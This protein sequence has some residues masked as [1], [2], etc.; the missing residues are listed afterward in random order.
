MCDGREI[1]CLSNVT[2]KA[3]KNRIIIDR[4][5]RRP[6]SVAGQGCD[7]QGRSQTIKNC[8]KVVDLQEL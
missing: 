1:S 7:E 8:R 3:F 6:L 5:G 4:E 2:H